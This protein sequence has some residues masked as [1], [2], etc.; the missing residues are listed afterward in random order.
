M[1]CRANFL[2]NGAIIGTTIKAVTHMDATLLT[3][4][5][6]KYRQKYRQNVLCLVLDT[7]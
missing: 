4:D 5:F 2:R 6:E 3:Y 7:G 1:G